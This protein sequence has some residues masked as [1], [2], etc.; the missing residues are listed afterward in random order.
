MS[1][2]PLVFA[3]C[4]FFWFIIVSWHPHISLHHNSTWDT[5]YYVIHVIRVFVITNREHQSKI[6]FEQL[7][8]RN[9]TSIY[10]LSSGKSKKR[11]AIALL[12]LCFSFICSFVGW[13]I[14]PYPTFKDGWSQNV[15]STLQQHSIDTIFLLAFPIFFDILDFLRFTRGPFFIT[16]I[17]P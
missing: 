10:Q 13:S 4:V 16:H 2:F 17:T 1:R 15:L 3:Y 14:I 7:S 12:Q 8:L 9:E 6:E 5:C 11:T